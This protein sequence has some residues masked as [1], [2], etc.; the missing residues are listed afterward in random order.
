MR[1]ETQIRCSPGYGDGTPDG[2]RAGKPIKKNWQKKETSSD[3]SR[4]T[5]RGRCPADRGS[6]TMSSGRTVAAKLRI[7]LAVDF[8]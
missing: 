1:S 5:Q 6:F 7:S 3:P 8:K 2:V 4:S